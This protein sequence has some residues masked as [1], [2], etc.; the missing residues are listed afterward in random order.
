MDPQSKND[1]NAPILCRNN[2]GFF[3]SPAMNNFCS[4][5]YKEY[6]LRS[7]ESSVDLGDMEVD[8][9]GDVKEK[10]VEV[11]DEAQVTELVVERVSPSEETPVESGVMQLTNRCA[12]CNRKVC[13]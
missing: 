4:K 3:G 11:M 5:C 6:C 7:S 8:E 1:E 2:C 10:K 9:K 12:V 13:I